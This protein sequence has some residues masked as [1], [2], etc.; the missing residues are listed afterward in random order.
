MTATASAGNRWLALVWASLAVS[1][2]LIAWIYDTTLTT[3]VLPGEA[4][5]PDDVMRRVGVRD[6]L[7][8]QGWFDNRF[9]Q[10]G[11]AA[12][13]VSSHWSRLVDLPLAGL[14]AA[15]RPWVGFE[16]AER[17]TMM[18]L[19]PALLALTMVALIRIVRRLDGVWA[20]TPAR[21]AHVAAV[22]LC[23]PML[24]TVLVQT[25][26]L[27][28]DHHGW[29]ALLAVLLCLSLLRAPGLGAG[30][31]AGA[32]ASV[33][34]A[35]SFE[36]VPLV[37]AVVALVA[38]RWAFAGG[39]GSGD[40]GQTARMLAGLAG[41]LAVVPV[42]V[43][44]GTRGP[45]DAL[46]TYCD[47][48]SFAHL[49][50]AGG[51]GLVLLLLVGVATTT[52]RFPAMRSRWTR[53]AMLGAAGGV[54][55]AMFA[56]IAPACLAGPFAALPPIVETFWY[57]NIDEGLP[58]WRQASD[59]VVVTLV[60]MI[61]GLPA[62]L[63]AWARARSAGPDSARVARRWGT[64]AWLAA[65]ASITALFVSRAAGVAH[66]MLLPGIGWAMIRGA[67]GFLDEGRAATRWMWAAVMLLAAPA[68]LGPLV[69]AVAGAM[70]A[71][72]APLPADR[73]TGRADR[74]CSDPAAVRALLPV[75]G[76]E[77]TTL[78]VEQDHAP[79]F[80]IDTPHRVVATGHHR[81]ADGLE[82]LIGLMLAPP[83]DATARLR[84]MGATHVILCR[85]G[86]LSALHAAA[87]PDG[88]AAAL[89][90]GAVPEGL[91]LAPVPV[92]SPYIVA[93]V[94]GVDDAG[95][96]QSVRETVTSSRR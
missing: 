13:G 29:Q 15:L 36:G 54:T 76:A 17:W 7:A 19:P 21:H 46:V 49:A 6:L 32:L 4:L 69:H 56:A 43:V 39:A 78:A 59:V 41:A 62:T 37:A 75:L 84:A 79:L 63:A 87:R 89:N 44:T 71:P 90:A 16:T 11:D 52:S 72:D 1:I 42:L 95:G 85:G 5:D 53:L 74:R 96:D 81:G 14:I 34:L 51:G 10:V 30:L 47:S 64:M 31:V 33:M 80:L 82:R 67:T 2:A 70:G 18:A 93:S 23:L 55:G 35:V 65:A 50:A 58:V 3:M 48:W 40:N 20:Q 83:Q 45:S 24:Q 92:G 57:Q 28:I 68:V 27:R 22:L 66:L 86:T 88:L 61:V 94:A 9:R 73:P 91:A 25:A 26:P 60:P 12:T 38:V 8:G 77:P